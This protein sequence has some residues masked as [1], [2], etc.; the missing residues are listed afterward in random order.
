MDK[1]RGKRDGA[2]FF[3]GMIMFFGWGFFAATA[4]RESFTADNALEVLGFLVLAMVLT[5]IAYWG[6]TIAADGLP[7]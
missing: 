6:F 5:A 2:S 1:D 7:D 4:M 3:M